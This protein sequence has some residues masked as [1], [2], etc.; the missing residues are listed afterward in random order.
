M[1]TDI[2]RSTTKAAWKFIYRQYRIVRREAKKAA[3]DAMIYG[4]GMVRVGSDVQDGIEH[5]DIRDVVFQ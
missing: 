2:P 5:V 3:L 1:I 4:S